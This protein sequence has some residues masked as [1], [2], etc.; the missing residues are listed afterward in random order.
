[1]TA[2][3]Y[4]QDIV[5]RFFMLIA[6]SLLALIFFLVFRWMDAIA[7]YIQYPH[8]LPNLLFYLS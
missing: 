8:R 1:M 5:F 7:K 4:P 3:H 2:C 6:S